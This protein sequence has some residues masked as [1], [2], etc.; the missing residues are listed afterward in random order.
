VC[1]MRT[2]VFRPKRTEF[3][4]RPRLSVVLPAVAGAIARASGGMTV[5]FTTAWTRASATVVAVTFTV[6]DSDTGGAV[7]KPVGVIV[8][9]LADQFTLSS[10]ALETV[11]ENCCCEPECKDTELGSRETVGRGDNA[12]LAD[13]P[14]QPSILRESVRANAIAK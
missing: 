7:Y 2:V 5:T 12:E 10:F 11:A 4:N 1:S 6:F 8:P 13:T 9:W 3:A 14:A